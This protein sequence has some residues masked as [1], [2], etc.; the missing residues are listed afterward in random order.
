MNCPQCGTKLNST[1][2]ACPNCGYIPEGKAVF[3]S[4]DKKKKSKSL[5]PYILILLAVCAIVFA[6]VHFAGKGGIGGINPDNPTAYY[7]YVEQLAQKKSIDALGNNLPSPQPE[8]GEIQAKLELSVSEAAAA[9]LSELSENDWSWL[10]KGLT[11]DANAAYNE[12]SISSKLGLS[13]AGAPLLD[14]NIMANFLL[15]KLFIQI[16]SL[17]EDYL[18]IEVEEGMDMEQ[19]SLQSSALS[20]S[21]PEKSQLEAEI[22]RY[23]SCYIKHINNVVKEDYRLSIGGI[24]QDCLRL[25]ATLSPEEYKA[26]AI[27]L[28]NELKNDDFLLELI[29]TNPEYQG[30]IDK[31]YIIETLDETISEMEAAEMREGN[32]LLSVI[33]NDKDEI[34]GRSISYEDVELDYA[35]ANEND[36]FAFEAN[37]VQTAKE[38]FALQLKGSGKKRSNGFNCDFNISVMG[39]TVVGFELNS[40]NNS[41]ELRITPNSLLQSLILGDWA[42]NLLPSN[43]SMLITVAENSGRLSLMSGNDE[44]LGLAI[45]Y[46]FDANGKPEVI[47][48]WLEEEEWGAKLDF[49]NFFEQLY[50]SELPD[51]VIDSLMLQLFGAALSF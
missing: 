38:P 9:L 41:Y 29:T 32:L 5:L 33:V 39:F 26:L 27:D 16:P 21:L 30:I 12:T 20:N 6:V 48:K 35:I 50:N 46:R 37:L 7:Q 25:T 19:F 31:Q 11:L 23:S 14:G 1:D 18:G 2:A 15:G 40:V 43:T 22:K 49:D 44:F 34:I 36:G 24:R 13:Y 8:A 17:C 3:Y 42:N 51:S 10:E 4:A 28:A 45:D 47:D